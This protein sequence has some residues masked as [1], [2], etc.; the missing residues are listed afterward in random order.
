MNV[1]I[2]ISDKYAEFHKCF[3][4]KEFSSK[5]TY[6]VTFIYKPLNVN[7]QTACRL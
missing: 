2:C 1:H 7:L 3:Y 6:V 4:L 5:N